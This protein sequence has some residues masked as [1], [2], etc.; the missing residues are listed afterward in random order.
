MVDVW[1]AAMAQWL[2]CEGAAMVQ[3]LMCEEAAMVQWLMCGGQPW[4]SG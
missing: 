2:M 4:L 3:W 1:G